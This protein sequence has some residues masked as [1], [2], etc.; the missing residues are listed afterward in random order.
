M[1]TKGLDFDNVGIVGVLGAD[2]L[3]RFPDFRAGERAYQLLTQVAGRAGRKHKRGLV[4]IQAWDPAHPVLKEV[5]RG[6]FHGH[7]RREMQER[8]EF[9]YPPFSR[10]IHITLQHKDDKIAYL[11]ADFFAKALRHSMGK[12]VLGPV[13][14]HVPRVRNYYGQEILLKMEKSAPVLRA[15][16]DLI[17][18]TADAVTSKPGWGQVRVAV[19]VDPV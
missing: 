5:Q 1:V 8:Q 7:L 11:A 13:Q 16:K 10:L 2:Q 6:D 12:R 15:A 14:P 3:T 19:D 17:L 18:K 4:L 9:F